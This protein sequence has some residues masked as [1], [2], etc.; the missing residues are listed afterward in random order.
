MAT[1]QAASATPTSIT[2]NPAIPIAVTDPGTRLTPTPARTSA[3][4]VSN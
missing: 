2:R 4:A 1:V 3:S